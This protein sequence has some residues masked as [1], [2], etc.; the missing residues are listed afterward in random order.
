MTILD[1]ISIIIVLLLAW[2]VVRAWRGPIPPA[3]MR[4]C[5][6]FTAGRNFHIVAQE[7]SGDCV[8]EVPSGED[9][10][11]GDT[12]FIEQLT[13]KSQLFYVESVALGSAYSWV[14]ITLSREDTLK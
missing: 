11:I 4:P 7:S 10:E 14:R 3:L 6:V 5:H 2:A 13:G 8:I 12:V 1:A 9:Y